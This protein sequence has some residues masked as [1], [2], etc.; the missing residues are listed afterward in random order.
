MK[1]LRFVTS[2]CLSILLCTQAAAGQRLPK[3]SWTECEP[4]EDAPTKLSINPSVKLPS[5]AMVYVIVRTPVTLDRLKTLAKNL[6][7]PVHPKASVTHP[8]NLD[9]AGVRFGF[10]ITPDRSSGDC[11]SKSTQEM[12]EIGSGGWVGYYDFRTDSMTDGPTPSHEKCEKIAL[13]FV[14]KTGLLPPGAKP[15]ASETGST[16]SQKD[17]ENGISADIVES[18]DLTISIRYPG[19]PTRTAT[20]TVQIVKDGR[21]RSMTLTLPKVRPYRTYPLKTANEMITAI[22]AKQGFFN[23]ESMLATDSAGIQKVLS[24]T[25]GRRTT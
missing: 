6:G 2:A 7:L 1:L 8:G 4:I 14:R 3:N 23:T 5:T 21:I 24:T 20:A 25:P 10:H 12:V 16:G 11:R 15:A 19:D 17:D 13:D 9:Y 22:R 18:R